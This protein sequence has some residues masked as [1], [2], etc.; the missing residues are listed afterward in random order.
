MKLSLISGVKTNL[1]AYLKKVYV[2][3]LKLNNASQI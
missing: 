1:Y 2:R 3:F